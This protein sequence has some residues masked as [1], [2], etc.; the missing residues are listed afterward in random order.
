MYQ[1]YSHWTNLR[2]ILYGGYLWQSVEKNKIRLISGKTSGNLF[3][4]PK[5][6]V[7]LPATLN[8]HKS[9][10]FEWNGIK[11]IR[12][13]RGYKH[14][15]NAQQCYDVRNLADDLFLSFDSDLL[16][17]P[18]DRPSW[19]KEQPHICWQ[20]RKHARFNKHPTFSF[21][22]PP[23]P[24]SNRLNITVCLLQTRIEF[25]GPR[26]ESRCIFWSF[27]WIFSIYLGTVSPKMQL[28][29]NWLPPHPNL[30]YYLQF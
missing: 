29:S 7:L 18:L 17:M 10:I 8:C 12:Q 14:Y 5:Y 20:L 24:S 26:F 6:V 30:T 3:E 23:S 4:G 16:S 1:R 25:R 11:L 15:A 22:H 9:A 28:D 2:G 13:P 27:P 21:W 19:N